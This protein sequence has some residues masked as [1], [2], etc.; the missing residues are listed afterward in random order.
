MATSVSLVKVQEYKDNVIHLAQ[1]ENV[2][3]RPHV[4][5]E[6]SSA[7]FRNW[8]RMG[9]SEAVERTK[10]TKDKDTLIVDDDYSRRVSTPR[11]FEHNH[12]FEDFD[13]VEMAISPGSSMSK[14]QGMAMARAYDKVIIEAA[15]GTALDG[16]G[17]A[18]ALPA[19][20]IH[21]DGTTDISFGALTNIQR[22]FMENEV[23]IDKPKVAVIGPG[24]VETLMQLTEQTSAD[25]VRSQ[26]LQQ[27]NATGICP[28]WMGFTWVVSNQLTVP[29]ADELYCL[30]MTRDAI[31][32][33]VNMNM[34]VRV[35]ENP[36]KSY[37]WNVFAQ[38]S[39]GAVRVEDE[40]IVVGHFANV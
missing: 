37:N 5:E 3:V 24:Q 14:S 36:A 30:F 10:T 38:F 26:A 17:A 34:K 31:G 20:Q 27:L 28:M 35:T 8:D 9:P 2:R 23:F 18:I 29:S 1:Q 16:E 11:V 33:Q 40:E 6:Q 39:A 15:T 13:R 12:T 32:L 7:E 4:M 21:G 25:Y 22:V 19:G